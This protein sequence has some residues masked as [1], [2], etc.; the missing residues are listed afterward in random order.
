MLPNSLK[1]RLKNKKGVGTNCFILHSCIR[2][3]NSMDE[4]IV[5]NQLKNVYTS[6]YIKCKYQKNGY[7]YRYLHASNQSNIV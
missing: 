7:Y 4:I 2:T 1:K 6:P 3:T 5:I